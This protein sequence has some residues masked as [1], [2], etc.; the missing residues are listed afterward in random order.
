MRGPCKFRR[1]D[2]TRAAKAIRAAG[3][4][5]ERIEISREGVIVIVLGKPNQTVRS[6]VNPWDEVSNHAAE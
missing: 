1:T 6:D 3:L 2:L 4:E 5:I